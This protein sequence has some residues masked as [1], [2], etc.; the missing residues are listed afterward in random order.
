MP[1]EHPTTVTSGEVGRGQPQPEGPRPL[2][3]AIAALGGQGGGV[4]AGWVVS[5]AERGGYL[6]QYTS[7]PGVAQR[8]GATIYYL[9]MFPEDEARQAGTEPVLALM[10]TSGDVDIVIASELME[11]GRS[12]L[13]GIVTKERTTLIS[14]TH[15][16]YAISEKSAMGDGLAP[17]EAILARARRDARQLIAFDMQALA[18]DKGCVI[19]AVLFGALAGSGALGLP[20]EA[21]EDTIRASGK[22]VDANLAGFAAGYDAAR[23]GRADTTTP[24]QVTQPQAADP[25][26]ARSAEGE[27]LFARVRAELPEAVHETAREGVR[28]TVDYQ[29][30]AYADLYL[31][32]LKPVLAVD[33]A[34]RDWGLT[35]E[36]ARYLALWM[37]YE[38]TIRVADLKTRASRFERFRRE[39]RAKPDQIVHVTE[40]MHPRVEEICDT[41][42]APV[43]RMILGSRAL[44]GFLGLFTRKGRHV[45]TNKLGG[46]VLL[47]TLAGFRRIRRL[48][49]R[50]KVEHEKMQA[51]LER[52]AETAGRDYALAV[53]IACCQRLIKGYGDT[54]ARGT[55]N[56]ETLMAN[57]EL[58]ASQD[59]PAARLRELRD[60]ALADEHGEQLQSALA[61][62]R[63]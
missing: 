10:P 21:F 49:L 14:S 20:R 37:T 44:R 58:V 53:E 28:R 43:G 4:L 56:Y 7:V 42:P 61:A 55:Q 27:R 2:T 26:Q 59:D 23:A 22:A 39:V 15:R 32:R 62:L 54:H 9:E 13:R 48:S 18:E 1:A 8:T 3:L 41:L 40:F 6:A 63:H 11:A 38:D 29:D 45:S 12:M 57:L 36:T 5:V 31:D 52:I 33:D 46:F 50:Y 30:P 51:W 17:G 24:E 16:V 19:S 34:E 35:R 25:W 47:H 60:A